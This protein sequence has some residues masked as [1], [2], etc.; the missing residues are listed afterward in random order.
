MS[1][2]ANLI[3]GERIVMSDQWHYTRGG[4]QIGPVSSVELKR[5]ASSG[6]LT[7]TDMVWKE[8]MA[9]WQAAQ[10]VRGLFAT[11]P[12]S[13]PPPPPAPPSFNPATKP[14]SPEPAPTPFGASKHH[15]IEGPKGFALTALVLGVV[16]AVISITPCLWMVGIVPDV[17]AIVFALLARK[18]I[19]EGVA[20]GAGMAK[21][22]LIC[23]IVGIV[24]WFISM[25]VMGKAMNDLDRSMDDFDRSMNR[26]RQLNR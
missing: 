3:A 23:G 6:Q 20:A 15:E 17:L 25:A 11:P 21:A 1:T 8:G 7:P 10:K 2:G 14:I 9:E 12:S 19:K 18:K 24:L 26:F 22:G 4:Q 5:L 13:T 16:G